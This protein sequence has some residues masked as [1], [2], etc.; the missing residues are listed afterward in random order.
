MKA[1]QTDVRST[2]ADDLLPLLAEAHGRIGVDPALDAFSGKP[3]LDRVVELLIV[4]WDRRMARDSAGALAFQG[5]LHF[6]TAGAI[7]D[8]ILLGY[9]TAV[10]LQT[11][12][13][14]KVA[15]KAILGE[16]P[17][18]GDVLQEG[19]DVI[20][21]TA[22][23]DIV[24]WL[25]CRYGS[26]EPEGY[27]YADLKVT[28]FDDAFGYG[29]PV[30]SRPTDGGEDT[31]SA[32]QNIT[33]AEDADAWVTTYV[34]VERMVGTFAADGTPEVFVNFPVGG[35]A[36]PADPD[37]Q[38]ANDDYVEGRYRRLLFDRVEIEAAARERI[39]LVP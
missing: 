27:R 1:I 25:L 20:L 31:I 28:C 23:S 30:F 32:S 4:D 3:D 19:R 39:V 18:G 7:R 5:F 33:F 2:L 22:A 9:D 8:D 37:T 38:V 36:D 29:M 10:G 21:L 17:E 13:V 11:I 24:A 6:L 15:A 12:F 26:V 35:R 16:Y 14:V 34:P